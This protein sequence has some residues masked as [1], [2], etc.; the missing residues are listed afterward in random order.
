MSVGQSSS[1]HAQLLIYRH[2]TIHVGSY[3]FDIVWL[4]YQLQCT[5]RP[6]CNRPT[7]HQSI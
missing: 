2:F 3:A 4:S 6:N 7:N 1:S 5:C